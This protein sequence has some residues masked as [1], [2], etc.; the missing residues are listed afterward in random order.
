MQ[1]RS[2]E[3]RVAGTFVA[4]SWDTAICRPSV[5][6][7]KTCRPPHWCVGSFAVACSVDL[8]SRDE[9]TKLICSLAPRSPRIAVMPAPEPLGS[10]VTLVLPAR[11]ITVAP[12]VAPP[13]PS[14]EA[15][16]AYARRSRLPELNPAL[17]LT[18]STR[19]ST[20][21]WAVS[22]PTPTTSVPCACGCACAGL[23]W[24][25]MRARTPTTPKPA[26]VM[27]FIPD[28]S[29]CV[30]RVGYSAELRKA[31]P[32][33][34]GLNMNAK[35]NIGRR[36]LRGGTSPS[37]S[38]DAYLGD[39]LGHRKRFEEAA[40][41]VCALL[42]AQVAAGGHGD[43]HAVQ[44]DPPY[45]VPGR[46]GSGRHRRHVGRV[47]TQPQYRRPTV[48]VTGEVTG[49]LAQRPGVR[50]HQ[51]PGQ[52]FAGGVTGVVGYQPRQEE[53]PRSPHPI[54]SLPRGRRLGGA[55]VPPGGPTC[56]L[57]GVAVAIRV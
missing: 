38:D 24:M 1:I 4:T 3:V 43:G 5:A 22:E 28:L 30:S 25:A 34:E 11:R 8:G 9:R 18:P 49:G 12:V 51:H 47:L 26:L 45:P 56:T 53:E 54:A 33:S 21:Y 16:K 35:R 13:E 42:L 50:R 36:S 37:T 27:L 2:C 41:V 20:P 19:K 39:Q 17:P 46:G 57:P 29:A 15:S 10:G 52:Y 48:V 44:R 40:H 55:G 32:R 31:G 6:N 23:A 14:P 7:W